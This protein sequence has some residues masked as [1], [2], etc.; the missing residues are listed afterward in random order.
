MR[1]L[2]DNPVGMALAALCGGLLV[3]LLAFS[4][5][6]ALAPTPQVAVE[7][8]N[9]EMESLDL[10][11]L[12]ENPPLDAFSVITQRPLFNESRQPVLSV[13]S[14][15]LPEDFGAED[16]ETPD[17][18]LSGVVITPTLRMVTLRSKDGNESL[19][20]FEGRPIEGE[21]AGWQV[22]HVGSRA[23]TLTSGAGE[24]L[25]LELQVHDMKIDEPKKPKER[26]GKADRAAPEAADETAGEAEQNE[27]MTRAEEIRQRIAERREELRRE[28]ELAEEAGEPASSPSYRDAIQSMVRRNRRSGANDDDE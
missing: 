11:E 10:P 25:Q 1:W 16:L 6:S 13:A 9:A 27:P 18:V 23:A 20:A 21:F 24:E 14:S 2:E 3:L 28:A 26:A 7:E 8:V 22:T 12:A 15:D 4:A 19:V 17:V 5:W